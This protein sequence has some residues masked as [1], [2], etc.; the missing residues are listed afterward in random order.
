MRAVQFC[1][2][3]GLRESKTDD[4]AQPRNRSIV[5]RPFLSLSQ[6]SWLL[7]IIAYNNFVVIVCFLKLVVEK[8]T[9]FGSSS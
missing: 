1:N 9:K 8:V 3:I 7:S 4:S 6:P 2:L 5:T